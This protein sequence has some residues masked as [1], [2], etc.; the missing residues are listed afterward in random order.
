MRCVEL[1]LAQL[2][3][4]LLDVSGVGPGLAVATRGQQGLTQF[5]ELGVLG[6]QAAQI[7]VCAVVCRNRIHDRARIVDLRL[8]VDDPA[9]RV[10]VEPPTAR[11]PGVF[12]NGEADLDLDVGE[13]FRGCA[14]GG[15]LR[16]REG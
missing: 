10:R 15:R 4:P 11:V 6:L 2:R 3:G 12:E 16:Q 14:G 13:R 5:L 7:S 9:D 8:L 1:G